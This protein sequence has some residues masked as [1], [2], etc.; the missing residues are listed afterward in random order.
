M[1]RIKKTDENKPWARKTFERDLSI[2]RQVRNTFLI[3]CEGTNT[4]PEYFKAFP[5]NT[6]TIVRAIGLGRSR[7]SL[8]SEVIGRVSDQGYLRNQLNYD[9][10]RQIWCVFD[11]DDRGLPGED[12]DFDEAVRLAIAN[13]TKPIR[14]NRGLRVTTRV[15][16][17][18]YW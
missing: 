3:Y 12:E 14:T 4:E 13:C 5:V 1:S 18:I 16:R 15:R 9:E 2:K 6:E 7:S 8:V 11:R 17:C 10:D